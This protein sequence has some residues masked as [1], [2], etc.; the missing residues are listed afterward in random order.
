MVW[1]RRISQILFLGLFLFLFLNAGFHP[2][3]VSMED[4]AEMDAQA[5]SDL[6]ELED[7]PGTGIGFFFNIDPLVLITTWLAGHAVLGGMLLALVTIVFTLLMGR[8]F[9][10]WLC[11]LGTLHNAVGSLRGGKT[12]DRT[13]R[14]VWSRWQKSK[15]LVLVILLVCSLLSVQLIGLLDPAS[16]LYRSTATVLFPAFSRVSVS[17]FNFLYRTDPGIGPLRVTAVS[18]P[19]YSYL[20]EH[21]LPTQDLYFTGGI[22]IGGLFFLALGLNLVRNRFWCKYICPLGALLGFFSRF[23]VFRVKNDAAVCIKCNQCVECCPSGADP[24][25][26]DGWHRSECFM[27]WNCKKRCP[28]DAIRLG[29]EMPSLRVAPGAPTGLH[30]NRKEQEADAS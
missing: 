30:E 16:F 21:V 3:T 19:V 8:F 11:P 23:T 12:A 14:G 17:F 25:L 4:V 9:C 13:R 18:E 27:C 24:H 7:H 26:P 10:G 2:G 20:R 5:A 29:F 6:A 28:V 22:L 15:Y 1:L